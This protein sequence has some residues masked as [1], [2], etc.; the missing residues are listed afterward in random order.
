MPQAT[1][2]AGAS[3]ETRTI[4]T[5]LL[6]I[7]F[8]LIGL[9]VMWMWTFWPKWVKALLS[10]LFALWLIMVFVFVAAIIATVDPQ[11]QIEK[12]EK[13]KCVNAC[14]YNE[15]KERSVCLEQCGAE[16]VEFLI[17]DDSS[18]ALPKS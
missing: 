4:V 1:K 3:K 13:V 14:V 8:P 18:R 7:F 2:Q 9:I 10:A 12:A 17:P 11:A 6:L 16:D 5:V 15:G